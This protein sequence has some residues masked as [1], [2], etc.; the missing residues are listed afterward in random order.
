VDR[1]TLVLV[2][3]IL[4]SSLAF[5]DAFI[6]SLALPTIRERLHFGFAGQQWVALSYS[7]A[8]VSLYLIAGAL[9]DRL[10]RRRVFLAAIVAFAVASAFAGFA[11]NVDQL[12]AARVFQ[13]SRRRS[14]RRTAWR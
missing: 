12:V 6:V 9:G 10:G 2:A 5:L 11:Q 3:T 1:R 4:G 8:L 13:G 14:S 7:L